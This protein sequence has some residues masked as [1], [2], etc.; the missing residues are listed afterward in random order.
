QAVVEGDK[1]APSVSPNGLPPP[2]RFATGRIFCGYLAPQHLVTLNL[3]QGPL[4]RKR[5][6]GTS[7]PPVPFAVLHSGTHCPMD[8]ETSSG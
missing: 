5:C 2:H 8:P 4:R 7:K 1:Q 3:F 6:V